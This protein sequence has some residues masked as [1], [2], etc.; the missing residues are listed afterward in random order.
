MPY[1]YFWYAP[2]GELI[3]HQQ[4]GNAS[5]NSPYQFS[6]RTF[7]ALPNLV[8]MGAR[9][10]SPVFS[11][12]TTVDPMAAYRSWISPYNYACLPLADSE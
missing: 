2:T 9:F 10:Y 1:E 5:Y 6:A 4:Q 8:Y 3:E 12:F 7:D 11:I